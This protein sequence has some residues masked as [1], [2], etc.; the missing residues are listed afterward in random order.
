MSAPSRIWSRGRSR[1]G[2][3]GWCPAARPAKSPTLSHAEHKRVI[4]LTIEV[5]KGKAVVMAGAGSNSTAEAVDFT[6]HAQQAGADAVLIVCPYYNKPTQ[7]GLYQHYKAIHEA[8]DIPIVIYNIPGPVRRRHVDRDDEAPGRAAAHHRRQGCDPPIW[9][10]PC[11]PAW[12]SGR[13]SA[14]CRARTS[15]LCRS[16]PRAATAASRSPPTL[17]RGLCAQLHKAWQSRDFATMQAG[18]PSCCAAAR[19]HVSS[20]PARRAVKYAASLM[21]RCQPDIRGPLVE[22]GPA[23]RDRIAAAMRHRRADQLRL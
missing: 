1:K 8:S 23:A 22:P 9:R 18:Q 14:C 10:A 20:R 15:R 3:T 2:R 13:N 11:A 12:R 16:W 7:E 4:E 6:R 17:R 19:R 21:G 5:A